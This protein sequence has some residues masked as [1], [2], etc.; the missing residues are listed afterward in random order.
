MGPFVRV[1][2]GV[3]IDRGAPKAFFL[4]AMLITVLPTWLFVL[5]DSS[6]KVV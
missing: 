6:V 1:C 5:S 4:A 3:G 2:E